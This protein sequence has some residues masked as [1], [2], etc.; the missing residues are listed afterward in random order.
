M[1]KFEIYKAHKRKIFLILAI[2]AFIIVFTKYL[3]IKSFEI[4]SI[5]NVAYSLGDKIMDIERDMLESDKFTD[6]EKKAFNGDNSK[7]FREFISDIDYDNIDNNSEKDAIKVRDV[8]LE[9]D[10]KEL[11]LLKKY[12]IELSEED[13]KVIEWKKIEKS[14]MLEYNTPLSEASFSK[15]SIN[16]I[17]VLI[18]YSASY[19][20][21]YPIIILSILFLYI[22][23]KERKTAQFSFY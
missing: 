5:D 23:S 10:E 11:N 22:I 8:I 16:P 9:R 13:K 3:S 17:R 19:F 20:G 14:K 4:I 6:E 15:F 1:L 21:L 18:Y 2:L 7:I 12:N